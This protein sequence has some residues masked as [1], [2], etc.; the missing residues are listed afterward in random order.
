MT[1]VEND[2][3]GDPLGPLVAGWTPRPRPPREPMI[4]HYCSLVP[5]DRHHA[6]GLF[7]AFRHDTAGRVWTYL[8]VGP[9]AAQTEMEAWIASIVPSQDP[10]FFAVI[11]H[12]SGQPV[13]LVS[14][15]R[16]DANAGVVEVGWVTW[17]PLM[18]KSVISTEAHYLMA[19]RA[20]DELGY[21]RY[22]WKCNDLNEPSMQAA[23]RLGFTY[24]GTFR[25]ATIVKGRNRDTAWFSMLDR[26]WPAIRAAFEAWLAPQNF[27]ADG[28][29][30]SRL[31]ALRTGR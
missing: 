17:S 2:V 28:R 30:L 31:E 19:R 27:D 4:G 3:N 12:V 5:L 22:E 14:Y 29:Q 10:L 24:E 20:F 13:G 16:I 6:P 8:S 9:F 21:R 11:D 23:R 15:L 1:E 7:E 18:Q 26:E 25:Q